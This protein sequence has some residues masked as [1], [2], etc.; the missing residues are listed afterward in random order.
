M[1]KV[2]AVIVEE[3]D[4]YDEC[5]ESISTYFYLFEVKKDAESYK[6]DLIDAYILEFMDRLGCTEDE[7]YDEWLEI[8][9]S[10]IYNRIRLEAEDVFSVLLYIEEKPI[11]KF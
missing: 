8:N 9:E 4:Y 6:Q 10:E 1:D 2:Y 5:S 3:T 7:L 11:M